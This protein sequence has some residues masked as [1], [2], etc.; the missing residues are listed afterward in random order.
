MKTKTA[1]LNGKPDAGNPHVRF[2]EGEVA[3]ENPRRESLLHKAKVVVSFL[4]LSL[5]ASALSADIAIPNGAGP[6]NW[7]DYL[8]TNGDKADARPKEALTADQTWV[9]EKPRTA[10]PFYPGVQTL[11]DYWQIWTGASVTSLSGSGFRVMKGN[12]VFEN[13]VISKTTEN[14]IGYTGPVK[15]LLRN[16]GSFL[17]TAADVSVGRSY[18]SG[19]S[20]TAT[21]FMDAP[22]SFAVSGSGM[23]LSIGATLPGAVWMDGGTLSMTNGCIRIGEGYEGYLRLNGG[24]VSL[25]YDDNDRLYVGC[26]SYGSVHISGGRLTARNTSYAGERRIKVGRDA[27]TRADV[28]ADDGKIDLPN[29]RFSLG[30][31]SDGVAG[32]ATLTVD[33]TADVHLGLLAMGTAGTAGTAVLNLNGGSF[34]VA[35]GLVSY[36]NSSNTRWINFDGGILASRLNATWPTVVYPGGGTIHVASSRN[37]VSLPFRTAKGYGV[38]SIELTSAG[39]GYVTAPCV[40]IT[41]GSGSNATAYAVLKKDRTLEK[42]VV[43]CR[44]EGY[45]E[46]DQ[47]T[48]TLDSTTGS[49]AAATVTLGEN[50][51]GTLHKTGAGTW[52]QTV[53]SAFDGD[54]SVDEGALAV[55]G[56]AMTDLKHLYVRNGAS[57]NAGRSLNTTDVRASS[58]NRLDVEDGLA[59]IGRYGDSGRAKLTIGELHVERGLVLVARTNDVELALTDA[60]P[61]ATSASASPIVNG[62][63]YRHGDSTGSRSPSLFERGADGTLSLI[64]TTSTAAKDANFCPSASNT[65]DAAPEVGSLNCAILPLSPAVQY[66]LKNAGP[67]EIKSGMIVC[68]CPQGNVMRL[69]V[70]GGGAFTTRA[71]GGM[72]IYSDLYEVSRR[73]HS[74]AHDNVVEKGAWRRIYGP[75]ADPDG[76]TPMA[77]TVAGEHQSRP[78][79][80]AVAWLLHENGFSGGVNLINGGVVIAK[81]LSL[82]SSGKITASGNCSITAYN[83]SF[84]ISEKHPVEICKDANLI[85]CPFDAN[86]GNTVASK[87]TGEGS[88]LTSDIDRP[89]FAMAYTG[90]HSDF[91]GAYYVMGHARIS[92]ETFSPNAALC[93]ADGT[94][95]VGVIETSGILARPFGTGKGALCWMRHATM[96]KEYGLCGGFAAKGGDLTVNLG[97]EGAALAC[98]SDYLPAGAV[99]QLQSQYA[100]SALT[101]SNGLDLCG[102]AQTVSVWSGKTA[103]LAGELKDSTGGGTLKVTGGGALAFGGTIKAKIGPDGFEGHPIAV[104]GNLTLDGATVELDASDADLKKLSG[105]TIPLVSV[106][107]TLSGKFVQATSNPR[108]IVRTHAHGVEL[109]ERKGLAIIVR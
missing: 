83:S 51:T 99:I 25:R 49:G 41:G 102:K 40:T 95:G 29:E 77:L 10:K 27:N 96:P 72:M 79:L 67:L 81:E 57:L 93:L 17:A 91:A 98:G 105:Q 33:G 82:G 38:K 58:V 30:Q 6:Y 76:S 45:A 11:S 54:L 101:V 53:D 8:P 36:G 75:F 34:R 15:L 44:G 23:K 94:N 84:A 88:L 50:G 16:G 63:V 12:V 62:M 68:R 55:D 42:I 64:A 35:N 106:S 46:N 20:G 39:S 37:E 104:D 28:Y 3:S 14:Y 65:S 71:S 86:Q 73:S 59:Q 80:G 103:K 108:W 31:W 18:N 2:D 4:S 43:T 100:D 87:L 13:A 1:V 52:Q 21:V 48:V 74:S 61:S 7:A 109:A 32:L 22:S 5:A 70:T 56:V 66:Y 97:G 78:E 90:D 85:F 69:A 9:V 24:E 26:T 60:T 89:G 92:P 19:T 107:G 47:L